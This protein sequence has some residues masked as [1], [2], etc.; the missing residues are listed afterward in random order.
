M[1]RQIINWRHLPR[2]VLIVLFSNAVPLSS[3]ILR[4]I[5][6]PLTTG[7]RSEDQ[8]QPKK[9]EQNGFIL[10][11]LPSGKKTDRRRKT[12]NTNR[13]IKIAETKRR[14]ILQLFFVVIFTRK[15]T[16]IKS[17]FVVFI[18]LLLIFASQRCK[19]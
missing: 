19:E 8:Q 3:N 5:S 11:K 9:F 13:R 4:R 18:L 10:C 16:F 15:N 17:L 6:C 7:F 2:T 14:L 12:L 1:S